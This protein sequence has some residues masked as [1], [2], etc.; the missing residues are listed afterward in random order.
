MSIH[1]IEIQDDNGNIYYPHSK[2]NTTFLSNG[3]NVD[4]EI[5]LIKDNIKKVTVSYEMFGAVGDGIVDDSDAIKNTHIYANENNVSVKCLTTKVY[6]IATLVDVSIKTSTDWN[7]SKFLINDK[8]NPLSNVFKINSTNTMVDRLDLVS[9]LQNKIFKTSSKI[10]ELAGNGKCIVTLSDDTKKIFVRIGDNASAGDVKTENILVDNDGS[11]LSEITF[12]WDKVTGVKVRNCEDENMIVGNGIFES[13]GDCGIDQTQESFNYIKKNIEVIRSNIIIHNIT[14]TVKSKDS[15]VPRPAQGFI[16]VASSN[17]VILRNLNLT[18]RAYKNNPFNGGVSV[19]TY[20]LYM[21]R[22]I[23]VKIEDADCYTR[24]ARYWGAITSNYCK[25]LKFYNCMSNRIDAHKGVHGLLIKDCTLGDKGITITGFGDLIIDN[26]TTYAQYVVTLRTDYGAFWNGDI[27][28]K[29]ITHKS[30]AIKIGL[31]S[32]TAEIKQDFGYETGFGDKIIQVENYTA[33]ATSLTSSVWLIPTDFTKQGSKAT[34][35][36]YR[37]AENIKFKNCNIIGNDRGFYFMKGTGI[38]NYIS[39]SNFSYTSIET[40]T[41]V[42]NKL[43]LKPNITMEFDN[44]KLQHFNGVSE[45]ISHILQEFGGELGSAAT[46]N[47]TTVTNRLLPK[48]IIKNCNNIQATILGF[49]C[50]LQLENCDIVSACNKSLGTRNIAYYNNCNFK[51]VNNLFDQIMIRIN[52]HMTF[53]NSCNFYMPVVNGNVVTRSPFDAIYEIFK[54][55]ASGDKDLYCYGNYT[56]CLA[57]DI[58][59]KVLRSDIAKTNFIENFG[60]TNNDKVL[61]L[62]EGDSAHKPVRNYNGQVYNVGTGALMWVQGIGWK[63]LA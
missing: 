25:N 38:S 23:N 21:F 45:T 32:I 52:R 53:F 11:I 12:D 22:C 51:P 41:D 30:E 17:N 18:P 35:N 48:F 39:N 36:G 20:S 37:L 16:E 31:F 58:N 19:G 7:Y 4:A 54:L 40:L 10:V 43:D 14:Q 34:L 55:N 47:Y 24:D 15:I 62:T 50:V 57:V 26:I 2:A 33:I 60:N 9:K 8:I 28:V 59:F 1:S 42:S 56:N 63:T 5:N 49:P 6:N 27:Y 61:Y 46:D 44:I 3:K 29:N 13:S